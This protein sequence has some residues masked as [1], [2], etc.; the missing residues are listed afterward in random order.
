MPGSLRKMVLLTMTPSIVEGLQKLGQTD[1]GQNPTT[2]LRERDGEPPLEDAAIGNPISHPQIVHIWRSLQTAGHKHYTLEALLKASM[3]YVPPPPPRP[4]QTD[5]YK[6][7]MERLRREQEQREYE[8]MKNPVPP[9]ETFSQ[10]FPNSAHL[11]QSF[12]AVNRPSQAA[13]MGDD[14]VTYSDV[15][16]QLMLILNFVA[17]ILGVAAT[18][19]ILARWWSTPARLFLTKEISDSGDVKEV[20]REKDHKPGRGSILAY[21]KPCP[22]SSDKVE[23]GSSDPMD[24][25]SAPSESPATSL[26]P[27]KRRRLTTK[28]EALEPKPLVDVTADSRDAFTL[29]V[30]STDANLQEQGYLSKDEDCIVVHTGGLVAQPAAPALREVPVNTLDPENQ[31]AARGPKRQRSKRST[32][33]MTQ[34]TLNLSIHK[35]TCFTI[36]ANFRYHLS[37]PIWLGAWLPADHRIHREWLGRS[38]DHIDKHGEKD[39]VPVLGEFKRLIEDNP[40]I[41]MYFTEMWDEIPSKPPYN[42]DPTGRSQIRDYNHMLQVLNHVF[43]RAPEWTEAAASVGMVGVPMAAIF[44]YAMGTPS[45]HAAFLDPDV[46]RMLKKILNEWG[47]YLKSP[48]S[49]EVMGNHRAGWFG[50]VG[51]QDL[52]EVANAPNKTSFKFEEMYQC[53]PS[54]EHFGFKSWDDFFTRKVRDSSRPVA[55]PDDERVIANPCE[56][57]VFNVTRDA[58]LRDK[59]WIKGQPYSVVDML[60]NSPLAVQFA[61][62]TVYQA[63]LSALSYHRWHA[64]VSGKVKRCFVSDGTYFSEPL[65][66]SSAEGGNI[67]RAGIGVAQGYL[68]ALATR[69]II[70]I[71]ADNPAVG[72]VAFIGVGMDEVSSCEITVREGQHVRKG[73]EIGMFHFGGS[74]FCLLFRK[75]VHVAGFPEVGREENVPII[76]VVGGHHSPAF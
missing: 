40:R 64:P 4:Q 54:Q 68:S 36:C 66:E 28:P 5:E 19:W 67:D 60:G 74:S 72:L 51:Y 56:S 6:A 49:A 63:F 55:S 8:R 44:D 14:D 52:M 18:L 43:G 57:K 16:R 29:G 76:D 15:H 30:E 39:L 22:P 21:F 10:Q 38:I 42:R 3:V 50:E 47:R 1:H 62:A 25:P 35:D 75:D 27:K 7:L 9:M 23:V 73:D 69:A 45:G 13:D 12:A 26:R 61:G 20:V 71:E 2:R 41:Y 11:A 58:K 17:S 32:K 59:F 37:K 24:T 33:D 48:E 70:F 65:F 46:N 53:D 31:A 34:T